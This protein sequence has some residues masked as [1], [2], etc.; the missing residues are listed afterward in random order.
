M[1]IDEGSEPRLELL[2]LAAQFVAEA[3]SDGEERVRQAELA[4]T[5]GR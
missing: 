5:G 2:L 1:N 4:V 3:V